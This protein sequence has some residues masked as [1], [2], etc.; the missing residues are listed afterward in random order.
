MIS[1]SQAW[2][3]PALVSLPV[4]IPQ[5]FILVSNENMLFSLFKDKVSCR[6][7]TNNSVNISQFSIAVFYKNNYFEY[8]KFGMH[9]SSYRSE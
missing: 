9:G 2:I 8:L 5:L 6:H 7:S 1:E 3:S 4:I